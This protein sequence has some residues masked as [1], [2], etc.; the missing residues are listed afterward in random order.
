MDTW[1]RET[2]AVF[3]A[4]RAQGLRG[5]LMRMGPRVRWPWVTYRCGLGAQSRLWAATMLA[6][7]ND[8]GRR[9]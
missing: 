7:A 6:A 1:T 4:L 8:N 5:T 3:A 2:L 9:A